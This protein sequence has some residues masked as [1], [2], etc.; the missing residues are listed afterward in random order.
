[1]KVPFKGTIVVHVCVTVIT[2]KYCSVWAQWILKFILRPLT[3][4]FYKMVS[5]KF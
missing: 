2:G 3:M 1:V 4:I 5:G